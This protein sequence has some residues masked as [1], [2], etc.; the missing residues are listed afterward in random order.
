MCKYYVNLLAIL[1]F[2][3]VAFSQLESKYP[4]IRYVSQI[5]NLGAYF[6]YANG[7]FH[8]DWYVGYNN[9]WIVKLPPIKKDGVE[10][11]YIG[12]KLGRAKTG[13][14]LSPV[15]GKIYVAISDSPSFSSDAGYFLAS[16]ED[17]PKEPLENESVPTAGESRWF[18]AFVPLSKISEEKDNYIAIWS[19]SDNFISSKTSPIIAGGYKEAEAEDVW[20]NR[21][22]KGIP[23]FGAGATETPIS[24]IKPA[25]AIKLVPNNE[26]KV[27]IKNFSAEVSDS[28]ILVSFNVI[29]ADIQKAWVEMSYDKFEWQKIGNYIYQS[30]Y[31]IS[32]DRKKL[33]Q[34]F[35]YLRV[36][37]RDIYENN[38]YSKEIKIPALVK[39][40]PEENKEDLS[41]QE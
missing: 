26:F 35:F 37:G 40:A 34:D 19:Q 1:M 20:L 5:S 10:K 41:Y 23:P 27:I 6:M 33:P 15:E 12:A 29:G 31:F 24:G 8:A 30:P 21:S 13:K 36:A 14:D 4:P 38:G 17:I 18:W 9:S 39:N 16:G 22:V 28:E 3:S 32:F 25:I 7:G 2:F 11:A